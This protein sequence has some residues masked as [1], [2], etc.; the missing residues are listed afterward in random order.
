MYMEQSDFI[1]L[2][3]G[4]VE[5]RGKRPFISINFSVKLKMVKCQDVMCSSDILD[6]IRLNNDLLINQNKGES[7]KHSLPSDHRSY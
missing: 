7:I 2:L 3:V 5:R 1:D 4:R 6:T